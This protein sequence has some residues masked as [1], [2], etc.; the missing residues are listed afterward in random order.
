MLPPCSCRAEANSLISSRGG[1]KELVEF[2]AERRIVGSDGGQHSRMVERRIERLFQLADPCDDF[3]IEQRIQV[4]GSLR[5]LLQRIETPQ[6]LHVFLGKRGHIGV[7]QNF[8][9][10]DLERRKRKRAVKTIA[11]ALP[12]S[13]DAGVAI[14][15]C[16]DQIGFVAG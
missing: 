11:A 4:A 5:L 7:G 13:G 8:D 16:S 9:Q 6:Q 14:K 12:L 2:L 10:G 1:V 15:K 3:R